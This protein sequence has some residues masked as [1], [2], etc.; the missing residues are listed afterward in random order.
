[1]KVVLIGAGSFVFG[2]TVLR[3]AFERHRLAE[4]HLALV[5]LDADAV[6][7]MAAL[8][9]RMAGD[10]GVASTI[11]SH[12]D[13]LEA[14]PGAD[15]VILSAAPEGRRRWLMD[16]AILEA[17]GMPDQ[18]RE[19]GALGGMANALR[20]ITLALGV[21]RDMERLCPQAVL[22]DVTNPMPRVVTAVNRFTPVRAYGFCNVAFG[23]PTGYDGIARVLG[24]P[25]SELS[26]VSAGLN[27]F[28]WLVSVRDAS[29]GEDLM[30]D[31]HRA[32]RSRTDG[33]G[34]V[35]SDWLDR[36]GAIAMSG[37]HHQA[38]WLPPDARIVYDGTPPYHG[39][40][41]ERDARRQELRAAAEGKR[42]W[43]PLVEKGSWEHP[44]DLAAAL[45]RGETRD[46]PI[47]NLGNRGY[48]P[49]LPDGRIVEVPA[50]TEGGRVTGVPI[51]HLPHGVTEVCRQVSD[52]HELIAEGAAT[53]SRDKLAEAVEGDIAIP[54]K[55][56][57]LAALDR[58]LEA[59]GD[60]L[61]QFRK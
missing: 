2:P 61:V 30:A 36:Y 10:L 52:V 11:T 58:M 50:R 32:V 9:R 29:T 23:G 34:P 8:G 48:W 24:R 49:D 20:A 15:Y 16:C 26:V 44:V 35:L 53:G 37:T 13:R 45:G 39:T 21:A 43:R 51:G 33:D 12:G 38:E 54:E 31:A 27:H 28:A 56:R 22:L 5:D 4:C 55:K 40:P 3:D 17:A 7:I 57:A 46:L 19:C 59:H 42:D 14:L 6:G 18:R 60:M 25:A 41:E 47:L 1:M